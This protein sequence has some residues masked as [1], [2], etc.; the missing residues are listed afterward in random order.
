MK[1]HNCTIHRIATATA[2]IATTCALT[3]SLVGCGTAASNLT[4]SPFTTDAA[5]TSPL[6]NTG[7]RR[8]RDASQDKSATILVYMNGSDLESYAGEASSDISEMLTSGVGNNVNVVIQTLGT[9]AWQDHGIASDHTQRYRLN[10]G[11]LELVDDSL[12]QLDTTAASTLSDFIRWG[13]ETYPAD[14][15]MLLMWDHGAGPVYGFGYD[16]FQ[17]DYAALTLDEMQSA[18]N[19]NANVH[20]DLIGMDCCLMSSI[21]TC[22]VLA[23]YC[24][25]TIL[26]EDFEPGVG[27]SY[28]KWLRKLEESPGIQTSE[29]GT[30]IVDEM[31]SAV[32]ADP[33]NG[34]ATLALID[35]SAVPGLFN[36]WLDFAYAN[37]D[38]LLSTN[39]SQQTAAR[40]RPGWSLGPGAGHDGNGQHDESSPTYGQQND[41]GAPYGGID[42][43]GFGPMSGM[44]PGNTG[45]VAEW[46]GPAEWGDWN[47]DTSYVTMSDYY[48]TDIMDVASSVSSDQT[49]ALEEAARNAI[50]HYG[51]TSGEEGMT[52]IGVTLPYGDSEFYDELVKVFTACGID[53]SYVDWLGEF[54][55]SDAPFNESEGTMLEDSL[56]G[57]PNWIGQ[58]TA[59]DQSVPSGQPN[60]G[61]QPTA[62]GQPNWGGQEQ[63]PYSTYNYENL[64][65]YNNDAQPIGEYT[66]D[67]SISLSR[68]TA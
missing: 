7:P 50:V 62:N 33:E 27:W 41:F 30:T 46:G 25:Y 47:Y 26:S 9:S 28:E 35:E 17:G 19:D 67:N 2:A 22:Q 3:F 34:E 21:E 10:N 57:Q 36:T 18:L 54:V 39:Y 40:G 11:K 38:A 65:N 31:I 49:A 29:L 23:P 6:P 59:N 58:P 1:R 13:V 56:S 55:N 12:G 5:T 52:G 37:K 61:N 68:L 32:Q 63:A 20:F 53:K 60:W 14:R 51:K 44:G 42:D 48:V 15:Y 16:E 4:P 66:T 8:A 64:W 24:D 43:M 45:D